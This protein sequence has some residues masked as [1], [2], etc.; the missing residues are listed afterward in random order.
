MGVLINGLG[1]ALPA[2]AIAQHDAAVKA[3]VTCAAAGRQ[4]QVV[5]RLYARSGVSSRSSVLLA[6]STNGRLAEQEFY[7]PTDVANPFGP[8]TAERMAVYCEEAPV[9]ARQAAAAALADA[10]VEPAAITHL[11]TVSCSG[12]AAPGVDVDLINSL[13][14][15]PTVQ[16]T[17]IGYMGCHGALNALRV[18][19][20]FAAADPQASVL[21]AAVELCSLHFQ[22]GWNPQ[23]IVA[24]SL[25]ADGAAALVVS[26]QRAAD[27]SSPAWQ[28]QD[29]FSMIFPDSTGAM[30]WRIG[31]NG[32]EM[33][34]SP[35]VPELIR[36]G[37]RAPLT[38]W[39][40]RHGLSLSE[41]SHWAVHPGGPRILDACEESLGMG[42][43]ALDASRHVLQTHGN[44]SSPTILFVLDE[45]RRRGQC[46]GVTVGLGFGPGLAMEAVLLTRSPRG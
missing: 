23:R 11:V 41:V 8:T 5:D 14:L 43:E 10:E 21:V 44:M 16:R 18:A 15:S 25:F 1:T 9:L 46:E 20:A 33:S 36:S 31:D 2:H 22:Y 29:S 4:Q 30:T 38:E 27:V 26:R 34:L 32:F 40:A 13:P 12:F 35:A 6:S 39:L 42:S 45:M 7:Q 24:N 28:V 19:R 3:G 17:H 37:L